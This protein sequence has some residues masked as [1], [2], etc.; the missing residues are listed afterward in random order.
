MEYFFNGGR[1]DRGNGEM[2]KRKNK[3]KRGSKRAHGSLQM[4]KKISTPVKY[5]PVK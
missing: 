2:G 3:E 5:V 4:A 1:G